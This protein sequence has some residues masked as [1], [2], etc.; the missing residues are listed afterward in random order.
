MILYHGSNIDFLSI[1]LK[2]SKVAKDFGQGF[3]VSDDYQQALAMSNNKVRQEGGTPIVQAYNFD[4][5]LLSSDLLR[6][7]KFDGYTEDWVRFIIQ[8]RDN[9]S[10][11][12][13]HDYDV[14]IGPIADDT[15][16]VQLFQYRKRYINIENLIENLKYKKL[17][18]QYFFGTER[19][20]SY[21]HRV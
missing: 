6:V 9:R 20:I 21:L 2:K 10:S 1:N 3:Y 14:V 8:N 18:I 5:S 12:Q 13:T 4:E 11:I 15:V 19:A 7:K 16:G 17:T